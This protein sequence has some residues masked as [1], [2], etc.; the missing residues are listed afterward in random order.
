LFFLKKKKK[1][2]QTNRSRRVFAF[3]NRST[4]ILVSDFLSDDANVER[5]W[6][7]TDFLIEQT[8]KSLVL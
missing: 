6:T 2:T 4:P 5:I 1:K 8:A 7:L 3:N